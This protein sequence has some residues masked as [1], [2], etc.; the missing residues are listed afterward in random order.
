[1]DCPAETVPQVVSAQGCKRMTIAVLVNFPPEPLYF[2]DMAHL[3]L[4]LCYRTKARGKKTTLTRLELG[5]DGHLKDA[6]GT[7]RKLKLNTYDDSVPVQELLK[8]HRWRAFWDRQW[9]Q[10]HNPAIP[11]GDYARRLEELRLVS[12]Y[13]ERATSCP[14]WN[15][16]PALVLVGVG[17]LSMSGHPDRLY[18]HPTW[19]RQLWR[20]WS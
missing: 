18:P 16:Q 17:S 13:R 10:R 8:E 9:G 12:L 5:E 6:H 14:Q 11:E 19:R 4:T 2:P 7:Y 3:D 20:T 1:M 15:S